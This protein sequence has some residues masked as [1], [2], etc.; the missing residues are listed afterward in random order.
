MTIE[1][2]IIKIMRDGGVLDAFV[3]QFGDSQPSIDHQILYFDELEF[4]GRFVCVRS[5][6]GDYVSHHYQRASVSIFVAG[7]KD[8]SDAYITKTITD[9]INVFFESTKSSG[10]I[11]TIIPKTPSPSAMFTESGRPVFE[12]FFDVIY[13]T[14]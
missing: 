14:A 13:K 9:K 2:D 3:D 6:G 7:F 5:Q 10:G 1:S 8:K 11:T 12:M 4:G